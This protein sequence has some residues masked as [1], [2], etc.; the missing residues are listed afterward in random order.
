M[1]TESLAASLFQQLQQGQGLQQVSQQL[2]LD[3]S[4]TAQAVGSALPLLLGAMGQN[5]SEPQGAQSLLNALQ[6]DHSGGSGFD[7]GGILG[8]VMGGGG[9]GATDGAG[10]LG[11]VFGGQ[12]PQAAQLLG[13]KTGLDSG[14]SGKLLAILAPIVMSFL[15]QRFAQGGNAGQLSQALGQETQQ[16]GGIGNLLGGV[17]DQDG[18]GQ[19]GASD[20]MKLGAGLLKR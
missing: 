11:H 18:D 10:I 6:R 8:A 12:Q 4:Q 7:L 15:A 16:S 17:L 19:F 9:S 2:G 1:N 13:Q 14:T 20:L 5:A 3:S